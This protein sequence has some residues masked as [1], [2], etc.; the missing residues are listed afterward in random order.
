MMPD[1][2]TVITALEI[3]A[4]LDEMYTCADC[5]Y[6]GDTYCRQELARATRELIRKLE[7]KEGR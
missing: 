5:P 7:E 2:E 4:R 6:F 3:C 1:K